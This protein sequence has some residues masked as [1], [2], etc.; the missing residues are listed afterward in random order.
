MAKQLGEKNKLYYDSGLLSGGAS[1]YTLLTDVVNVTINE[2]KETGEVRSRATKYVGHLPSLRLVSFSFDMIRD[3][4]DANYQA[5]RDAYD[6]DDPVVF[7]IASGTVPAGSGVTVAH[8]TFT[9]F[10]TGWERTEPIGTADAVTITGELSANAVD[11]VYD[12]ETGV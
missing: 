7:R 3:V 2:T 9:V 10:L 11:P 8:L 5:L 12:T 1:A 6:A 4:T